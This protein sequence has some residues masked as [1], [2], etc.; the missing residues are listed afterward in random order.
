MTSPH[1]AGSW[2]R[3]LR[4]G[5]RNRRLRVDEKKISV[6]K[7]IS[8]RFWKDLSI[9]LSRELLK[10]SILIFPCTKCNQMVTIE[11]EDK[12]HARLSKR[13]YENLN[14]SKMIA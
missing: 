13:K 14:T 2:V 5:G 9:S 12:F 3:N 4:Y 10:R 7:N 11:V 8:S 6:L 1:I